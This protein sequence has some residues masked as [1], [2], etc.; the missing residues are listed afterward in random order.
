MQSFGIPLTNSIWR[1]QRRAHVV[2]VQPATAYVR[3]PQYTSTALLRVFSRTDRRTFMN[4]HLGL[5][6]WTTPPRPPNLG[7][8]PLHSLPQQL[9]KEATTDQGSALSTQPLP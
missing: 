2:A 7:L 6:S 9:H 1:R 5:P 3:P 8:E 4:T